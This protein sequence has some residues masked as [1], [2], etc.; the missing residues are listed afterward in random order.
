MDSSKLN[1]RFQEELNKLKAGKRVSVDGWVRITREE[2][3]S[4]LERA[5][6]VTPI[7]S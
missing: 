1:Q 3:R 6:K 4:A 7:K 2:L 5:Q